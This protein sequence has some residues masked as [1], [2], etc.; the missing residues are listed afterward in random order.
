MN[1]FLD[2]YKQVASGHPDDSYEPGTEK[3]RVDLTEMWKE[4]Q[5]DEATMMVTGAESLQLGK[6][7]KRVAAHF[8]LVGHEHYDPFPSE[9]NARVGAEGFFGA[10]VEGF[11]KFIE[12]IIKYIRMA[13]NWVVDT[14]KGIFGFRKS[15]RINK[16]INDNLGKMKQEFVTTLSGL[17]FPAA[18][19]N[20]ENFLMN[21]PPNQD[22]V[23]QLTL[24]K[25]KFETDQGTIDSLV[26]AMPLLQ[27]AMVKLNQSADKIT[28]ANQALRTSIGKEYTKTRV[29]ASTPSLGRTAETSPEINRL[30]KEILEVSTALNVDAISDQVSKLYEVLYSLKFSNEELQNG[31]SECRKKIQE[32]LVTESVKIQ[33]QDV[34][35]LLNQIQFLNARYIEITENTVDIQKTDFRKLGDIVERGEADKIE[36]IA[37]YYNQPHLLAA[38]QQLCVNVRSYTQFCFSVSNSLMLVE[39]Q[40]SNLVDWY[41][42]AHAY[43]YHA[44]LDDM[45][46]IAKINQDARSKGHS[47]SA[48]V[49]GYPYE[50]DLVVIKDADAKTFYER[51]SK[52]VNEI[53]VQDLAGVKTSF[54]NFAK[55][56][57]WGKLV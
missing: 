14:V 48:D 25:S 41:N 51:N 53:I 11:K 54:N 37:G 38:Y 55:Q 20:V 16:E 7:S 42:R 32:T 27:Q 3:Q 34:P 29:R 36:Q 13:V 39:R 18:D 24:M 57:G 1:E 40:A 10:I 9:R 23:A 50:A 56:T 2:A 30:L 47:P 35:L 17:G 15:A 19:Y 21:L 44:L 45:D 52:V 28:R 5:Q 6:F 26:E 43:Y 22:R 33:K 49:E 4:T 8:K 12:N 46:T 31:F